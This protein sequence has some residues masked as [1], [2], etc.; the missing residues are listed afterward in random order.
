VWILEDEWLEQESCYMILEFNEQDSTGVAIRSKA[1]FLEFGNGTSILTK[2]SVVNLR[3]HR[4]AEAN[5]GS[6]FYGES[7]D[8]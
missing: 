2:G 4:A 6:L 1:T 7:N 5:W 3:F 8:I